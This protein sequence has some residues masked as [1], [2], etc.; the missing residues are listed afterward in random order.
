MSNPLYDQYCAKNTRNRL[1]ASSQLYRPD[2]P[3]SGQS[4]FGH[5]PSMSDCPHIVNSANVIAHIANSARAPLWNLVTIAKSA[6]V[7]YLLAAAFPA[8]SNFSSGH[9]HRRPSSLFCRIRNDYV[10]VCWPRARCLAS[11]SLLRPRRSP[12][13]LRARATQAARVVDIILERLASVLCS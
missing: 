13:L 6:I 4:S 7:N 9:V 10:L 5:H 1:C 12:L 8:T 3:S 11:R 2:R